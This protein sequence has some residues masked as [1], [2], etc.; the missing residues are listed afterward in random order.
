MIFTI[1]NAVFM[2]FGAAGVVFFIM[3]IRIKYREIYAGRF[4]TLTDGTVFGN[5]RSSSTSMGGP[6]Y[7]EGDGHL[8]QMNEGTT[9]IIYHPMIEYFADSKRYTLTMRASSGNEVPV[10][11]KVE[12]LYNPLKP[13]EAVVKGAN[14]SAGLLLIGVF[15][16]IIPLFYFMF[17]RNLL[18]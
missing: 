7:R 16:I 9:S 1:I 5:K 2:I 11:K 12:V 8:R 17:F 13:A 4:F 18:G 3:G 10:G 14:E 15:F 6:T